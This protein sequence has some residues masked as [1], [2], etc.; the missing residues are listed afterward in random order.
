[1]Y[2]PLIMEFFFNAP[3]KDV[4]EA[5][6]NSE[7]M[8]IWYFPQLKEFIPKVGYEFKFEDSADT[9]RK[10]W[11]V[12]KINIPDTL[13]HSWAYKG[14]QGVSEVTF[15]L[16]STDSGTK[17][18]ITHT[19]LESFPDDPHFKRERFEWGWNNLLGKNLKILLEKK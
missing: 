2:N 12:T 10:K 19:G 8:K 13:A 11:V 16:F 14:Y 18:R 17:I 5:M 4:W 1:M 3:K 7:K 6:T 9:Y 15:D